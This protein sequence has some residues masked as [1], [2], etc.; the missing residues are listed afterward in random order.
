MNKEEFKLA[1]RV[2]KVD[3]RMQ[4]NIGKDENRCDQVC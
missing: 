2:L 1:N 4:R 3:L